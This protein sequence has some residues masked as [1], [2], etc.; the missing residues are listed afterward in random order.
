V[1]RPRPVALVAVAPAHREHRLAA[2]LV[3]DRVAWAH[4]RTVWLL[5]LG[6]ERYFA[7]HGFTP[8][9]RGALPESLKRSAQLAIPACSTAIAMVRRQG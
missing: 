4:P 6:A 3:A 1:G 2:A 8:V 5:T 9:E 7:R